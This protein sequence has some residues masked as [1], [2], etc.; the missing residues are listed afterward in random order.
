MPSTP[1][2]ALTPDRIRFLEEIAA[3]ADAPELLRAT[4]QGILADPA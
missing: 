1:D 3:D 2:D 4:A